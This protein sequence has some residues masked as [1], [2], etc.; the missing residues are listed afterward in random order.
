MTYKLGEMIKTFDT[1]N[2]FTV[3]KYHSGGMGIVY[4]ARRRKDGKLYALKTIREDKIIKKS[5]LEK[6]T[7]LFEWES[8]VWIVLGKHRNTASA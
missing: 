5:D 4:I 2:I 7:S 1:D 6:F 8:Q 3:E